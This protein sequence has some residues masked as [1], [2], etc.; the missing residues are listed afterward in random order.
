M[1]TSRPSR[2]LRIG[3][4]LASL[5]ALFLAVACGGSTDDDGGGGK[6]CEGTAPSCPVAPNCTGGTAIAPPATC[7]EGQWQCPAISNITCAED[8]GP[9]RCASQIELNCGTGCEGQPLVQECGP[10]GWTCP[11]YLSCDDG[12]ACPDVA[13]VCYGCGG[14]TVSPTCSGSEWECPIFGCP[15]ELDGGPGDDDGGPVPDSGDDDGGCHGHHCGY[16]GGPYPDGGPYDGGPFDAG[17][18]AAPDAGGSFCAEGAACIEG[19]SCT[20]GTAG[21]APLSCECIGGAYA[22]TGG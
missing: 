16:D 5:S 10:T 22:C 17:V 18:D 19:M 2:F 12:G 15:I 13:P 7:D 3:L 8:G 20:I 21:K 6:T 1:S 11:L 9:Y 4:S 14:E